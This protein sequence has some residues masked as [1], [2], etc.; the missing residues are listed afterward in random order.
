VADQGYTPSG[1]A[2]EYYLNDPNQTPP[3]ELKTRV[4]FPVEEGKE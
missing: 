3:E 4:V 2:Y 1:V